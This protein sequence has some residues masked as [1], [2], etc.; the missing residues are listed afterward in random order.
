MLQLSFVSMYINTG[1]TQPGYMGSYDTGR[2]DLMPAG[3]GPYERVV[4]QATYSVQS[5]ASD[6]KIYPND[7]KFLDRQV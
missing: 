3:S 5:S 2:Q 1:Y 7:P 4:K 6:S